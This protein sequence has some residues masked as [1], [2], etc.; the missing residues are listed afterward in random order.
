[1]LTIGTSFNVQEEPET[2]FKDVSPEFVEFVP[3]TN[4]L[5]ENVDKT[6]LPYVHTEPTVGSHTLWTRT[7]TGDVVGD[8]ADGS[9]F[10]LLKQVQINGKKF[11]VRDS[12]LK[13]TMWKDRMCGCSKDEDH[14]VSVWYLTK[15]T[16]NN[17]V[18]IVFAS[19]VVLV[20]WKLFF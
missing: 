11:R 7:I 18:P 4:I 10:K 2:I 19:A 13:F 8:D 9:T 12:S 1:M 20:V 3:P 17:W 6:Y 15:L 14:C 16:P 5:H